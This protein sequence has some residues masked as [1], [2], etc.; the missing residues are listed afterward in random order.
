MGWYGSDALAVL[1]LS[2]GSWTS[3]D[4][5]RNYDDKF[6]LWRRGYDATTELTPDL[7]ITGVKLDDDELAQSIH[8]DNA[9]NAS[10]GR[11]KASHRM[12]MGMEFPSAGCWKLTATYK[13]VD[14][15]HER[16]FVLMVG[17]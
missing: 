7:V 15:V 14:I 16:T 3:K 10:N 2:D 13:H 4:Q 6:W 12:L 17:D 5:G 8:I 9:T 11:D 1:I